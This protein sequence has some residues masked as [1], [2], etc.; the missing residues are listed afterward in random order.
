MDELLANRVEALL[1][2]WRERKFYDAH[3]LARLVAGTCR[4]PR[5]RHYSKV[6]TSRAS[7]MDWISKCQ[8]GGPEGGAEARVLLRCAASRRAIGFW[9]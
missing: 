9:R 8:K 2:A 6:P 5:G 4:G 7:A 3:R 1:E